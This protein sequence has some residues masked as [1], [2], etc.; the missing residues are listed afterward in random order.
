MNN[1]KFRGTTK[2]G[3]VVEGLLYN[4][5]H[6]N[7]TLTYIQTGEYAVKNGSIYGEEVIPESVECIIPKRFKGQ[8]VDG[9]GEVWGYLFEGTIPFNLAARKSKTYII[10]VYHQPDEVIP[11][12]VE[13]L[14]EGK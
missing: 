10:S 6:Y 1:I 11:K 8:R 3:K 12:T 13:P 9:G 7:K 4:V 14:P 2:N 5:S